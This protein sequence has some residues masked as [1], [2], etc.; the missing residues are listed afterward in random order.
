MK[1]IRFATALDRGKP[2]TDS[3]AVVVPAAAAL[4]ATPVDPSP[5]THPTGDGSPFFRRRYC[6]WNIEADSYLRDGQYRSWTSCRDEARLFDS[7]EE[8]QKHVLPE[9]DGKRVVVI[10]SCADSRLRML[11]GSL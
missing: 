6:V 11:G 9:Y 4:E 5:E 1:L 3:G 7:A 2:N 8:A 10:H